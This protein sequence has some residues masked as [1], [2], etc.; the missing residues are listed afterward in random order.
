[1]LDQLFPRLPVGNHVGNGNM[2]E[3][4]G[5]GELRHLLALHD[6]SV[7]VHQFADDANRRQA[8]QLAE[9]DR[10]LG[11][12]RAQQHPAVPRNQRKHVAGPR[13]I[14]APAFGLASA[15]QQEAR[16]SAEIPVPPSGL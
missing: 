12:A 11:M 8:A 13:E 2:L 6:G 1:M 5:G 15:R 14:V 7:V 16:S 10:R 3:P 9:I 4:V